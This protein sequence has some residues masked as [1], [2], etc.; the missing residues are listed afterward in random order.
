MT[1]ALRWGLIGASDIAATRMIPA[2]RRLRQV[3]A[4]V[5]SHDPQW[6]ARFAARHGLPRVAGTLDETFTDVDAVYISSRNSITRG[7]GGPDAG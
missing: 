5:F 4:V 6:G 2:M 3:P 7:C 1:A